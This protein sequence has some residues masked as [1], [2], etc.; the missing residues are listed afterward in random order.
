MEPIRSHD[1][2]F[3]FVFG[4][5][6][7]M[8]ELLAIGL[9]ASVAAAIDRTSLQRQDVTFVDAGLT[10]R[11][12]DLLFTA[13]IGG[14]DALLYVLCEHKS[15][16]DR[17]TALQLA[18][19][20]VRVHD[21]WQAEHPQATTLPPVLPFVVHHGER[22]WR[23]PRDVLD[24]VDLAAAP[25]DLRRFL[26]R[27]Q[28]RLPFLLLDLAR[29]GPDRLE[30]L[31]LSA[32]AGLTLRFLQL[33]RRAA[34]DRAATA[35]QGWR[36]LLAELLHERRGRSVLVALASWYTAGQ[37]CSRE[38]FHTAMTKIHEDPGE[39]RSML[40]WLLEM[41]EERGLE[42][43]RQQGMQQALREVLEQQ[44]GAQFGALPVDVRERLG[45]ADADTLRR[46][47]VGMVRATSLDDVFAAD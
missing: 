22:P 43:G 5:G 9:P 6:D 11:R 13:R 39:V 46:W 29:L 15:Q 17:F 14:A 34:P 45:A 47:A 27:R 1:E 7:R 25:A 24:L 38:T 3:R 16:S 33:L 44:L 23:A 42:K 20:V 12:S 26:R 37:S 8:A 41:G 19:Y 2:L 36:H 4:E 21:R 31:Q 32:A 35:I 30:A 28:L 40:D 10:E 18:R